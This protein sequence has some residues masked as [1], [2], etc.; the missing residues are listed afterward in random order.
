MRAFAVSGAFLGLLGVLAPVATSASNF[1]DAEAGMIRAANAVKFLEDP[2]TNEVVMSLTLSFSQATM[3]Q[4]VEFFNRIGQHQAAVEHY[5]AADSEEQQDRVATMFYS[6]SILAFATFHPIP[7]A[8]WEQFTPAEKVRYF[9]HA[10]SVDDAIDMY[11]TNAQACHQ[12]SKATAAYL[13]CKRRKQG[14][15]SFHNQ[16]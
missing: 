15:A 3:P 2:P 7:G 1:A 16:Y 10:N 4:Q 14:F 11:E 13:D 12:D 5:L 9:W 8:T 6:R